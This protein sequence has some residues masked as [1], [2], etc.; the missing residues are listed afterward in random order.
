M[1]V[2]LWLDLRLNLFGLYIDVLVGCYVE[3]SWMLGRCL[4][5]LIVFQVDVNNNLVGF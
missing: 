3:F 1:L 5:D 2:G 4:L